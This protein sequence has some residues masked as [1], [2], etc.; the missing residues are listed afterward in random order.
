MDSCAGAGHTVERLLAKENDLRKDLAADGIIRMEGL[1]SL[2]MPAGVGVGFGIKGLDGRYRLANRTLEQFIVQGDGALAGRSEAE[3]L[4]SHLLESTARCD[5]RILDGETLASV[6]VEFTVDGQAIPCRW[7]KLPVLGPDQQLQSI[8]SILHAISEPV[9]TP[10][11]R[12]VLDRLHAENRDL[13]QAVVELQQVASTDKLTGVWNRRRLEECVRSEMDRLHRYE[14][15]VSLLIVDID[16]FKAVNDQHGHFT[17]DQ[18]LQALTGRLQD[19]LRATD[20]LARWGGEEFVVLC[21]NTRRATAAKLAER[22]RERVSRA[23]FPAIGQLTVSIGVAECR[24]GE[25]WEEWFDR[26]DEALYRAK[27]G[28]RNQVQVA[29][30]ITGPDGADDYVVANFV[31]LVWRSAYECGNEIIDRDHR[32]L[33][34]NANELLSSMLSGHADE[35][36]RAIVDRLITDVLQH[37]RDEEA[38]FVAAGFPGAN[39]HKLLHRELAEKAARIVVEYRAGNQ[40]VGDVFQFLAYDVITKHL[41]GADRQFFTYLQPDG[42]TPG[43]NAT[44]TRQAT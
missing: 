30:E 14:H 23:D 22:L 29:Q 17:G 4:P 36:V 32:Q 10:A 1:L 25:I 38:I 24:G 41:L 9:E 12:Q 3:L 8:A 40:N 44:G 33:F 35:E 31:H 37:F 11:T 26:A 43:A 27:S 20:A 42:P 5:Q 19:C 2:L 39:E 6:E 34:A 18:V 21:S 28:G 13:Q 7:L 16:F 15:P